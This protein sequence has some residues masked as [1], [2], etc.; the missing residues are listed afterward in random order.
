MKLRKEIP[1]KLFK[2]DER[3]AMAKAHKDA[4]AFRTTLAALCKGKP[5]AQQY[6]A[7]G[8]TFDPQVHFTSL[9]PFE[10]LVPKERKQAQAYWDDMLKAVEPRRD[11]IVAWWLQDN[12]IPGL[13]FSLEIQFEGSAAEEIL[14][15]FNR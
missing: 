15:E 13:S 10:H 7:A 2:G 4:D 14:E 5:N 6:E 8:N 9:F 11:K 3:I 1:V 12:L